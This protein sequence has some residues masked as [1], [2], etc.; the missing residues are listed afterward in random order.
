MF[1]NI[2]LIYCLASKWINGSKGYK[3]DPK[4]E[5]F[6]QFELTSELLKQIN[7]TNAETLKKVR[8]PQ[9]LRKTS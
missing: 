5:K 9:V 7:T 4:T 8:K 3:F 1:H 2:C 6:G